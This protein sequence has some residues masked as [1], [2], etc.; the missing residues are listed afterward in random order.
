M[1]LSTDCASPRPRVNEISYRTFCCSAG[2]SD[3]ARNR[4]GADTFL[5]GFSQQIVEISVPQVAE[6]LCASM[7]QC[8]EKEWLD[9]SANPCE[10]RKCLLCLCAPFSLSDE[11]FQLCGHS[12]GGCCLSVT[13]WHWS[14]FPSPARPPRLRREAYQ[15]SNMAHSGLSEEWSNEAVSC[16]TF[17]T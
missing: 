8:S 10:L 2:T 1:V 17:T 11:K 9:G 6:Q 13:D 5:R 3:F 16:G 7:S 15:K 4:W 14:L 12:R